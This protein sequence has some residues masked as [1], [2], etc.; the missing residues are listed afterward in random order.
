M[1]CFVGIRVTGE[2]L[3]FDLIAKTLGLG[4]TQ[5]QQERRTCVDKVSG[6]SYNR[7]LVLHGWPRE[8]TTPVRDDRQI[9]GHTGQ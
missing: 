2:A 7:C 6:K 3:D 8:R 5:V 1:S 4:P 9:G